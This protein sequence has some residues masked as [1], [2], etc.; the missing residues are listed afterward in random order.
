MA[1]AVTVYFALLVA[2]FLFRLLFIAAAVALGI[3]AW[4]AWRASS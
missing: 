3:M 4:R 1:L 2:G